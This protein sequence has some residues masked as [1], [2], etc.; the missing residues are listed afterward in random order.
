M[1]S[2][3]Q[4]ANRALQR[5]AVGRIT[6]FTEN[7][8]AA[9]EVN[10][11]FDDVVQEVISE[12]A[13]TSTT[14]RQTLGQDATAPDWGYS[15]RYVLPTDPKF[16][17]LL[18]INETAIGEVDYTIENGYLLSNDSSMK[19][20]YKAYVTDAQSY[21]PQLV[22][23]IVA[24]LAHDLSYSFTGKEGMKDRLLAEYMNAL[25]TGLATDGLNSN[26]QGLAGGPLRDARQ[27]SG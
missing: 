10:L 20:K 16:L 3:V 4:I 25:D 26:D 12:G 27:G 23:A 14:I 15:Y 1:A 5:L 24:K 19:I 6:A 17:G 13:W 9:K 18:E 2:K 11:I 21:D 22:K 8:K 7:T